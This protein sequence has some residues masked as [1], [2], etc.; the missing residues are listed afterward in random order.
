LLLNAP[1]RLELGQNSDSGRHALKRRVVTDKLAVELAHVEKVANYD[2][3]KTAG[4][5]SLKSQAVEREANYLLA[6]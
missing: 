3:G 2:R 4:G 6:A 5:Y 1:E